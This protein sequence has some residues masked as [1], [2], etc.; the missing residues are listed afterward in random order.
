MSNKVT[1]IGHLGNDPKIRY[2]SQ[3]V[4]FG[5]VNIAT[6]EHYRDNK[7][8]VQEHTEWHRCMLRGKTAEIAER[9]SFKGQQVAVFGKLR[10]RK[11][12]DRN[13]IE[14]QIT[15]VMVDEYQ[16]LSKRHDEA[17]RPAEGIQPELKAEDPDESDDDLPF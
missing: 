8:D 3:N 14:R 1:L 10:T 17:A 16:M 15:E 5:S 9:Y 2:N 13:E 11:Y 6:K 7:G 12:V 4:A